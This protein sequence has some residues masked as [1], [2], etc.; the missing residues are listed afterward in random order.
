MSKVGF[1]FDS[2][3]SLGFVG[4]LALSSR[5]HLRTES[6]MS[7]LATK[8]LGRIRVFSRS[9]QSYQTSLKS[10]LETT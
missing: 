7:V 3:K 9:A 10:E 8:H 2:D 1:E 5:K 4:K 6:L